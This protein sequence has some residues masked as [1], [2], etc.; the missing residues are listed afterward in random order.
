M[1]IAGVLIAV[2][3]C[4][5]APGSGT[6]DAPASGDDAAT[7]DALV[8]QDAQQAL[9]ARSGLLF[10]ED[11]EALPIGAATSSAWTTESAM[12]QLTID[13]THARGQHALELAING[14]GRARLQK[15]LALPSNSAWGTMHAWVSGF[16]TAPDYAHY[17]LV[18]LAGS[19]NTSLIRPIGGQYAP[20]GGA[21]NPAGSFWGIGSDGG[22]TGDWC[23]WRRTAPSVGGQWVCLEFHLDASNNAI[24][25]YVDGVAK[26]ELSVTRTN[27]GGNQV[28]LVFPTFDRIWFGWWLYQTNP[29]PS[30]YNVWLDDIALGT[31]RLGC[32]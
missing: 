12:G 14:N 17:T 6:S 11:F 7:G 5:S 9:C 19:G 18:E 2:A 28:D 25:V 22:A 4:G 8:G 21:T 23:N 31:S 10:C 20:A 13:A 26:P 1:R 27:H 24:D 15:S 32:D 16:P 30:T 3:A 29:T